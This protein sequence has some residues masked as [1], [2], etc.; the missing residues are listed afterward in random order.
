MGKV[1]GSLGSELRRRRIANGDTH[2]TLSDKIGVS[3]KTIGK[4]ERGLSMPSAT[5]IRM[6]EKLGLIDGWLDRNGSREAMDLQSQLPDE[7]DRI[8]QSLGFPGRELQRRVRDLKDDGERE[9][10]ALF[11][12]FSEKERTIILKI[13]HM[14]VANRNRTEEGNGRQNE[15]ARAR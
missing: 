7:T 2:D 11:R 3:E 9:L 12:A 6:L 14:V 1:D 13:L 4:W 8:M 15:H 5:N 10:V